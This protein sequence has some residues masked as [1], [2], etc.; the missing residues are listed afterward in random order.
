MGKSLYHKLI[1]IALVTSIAF[2]GFSVLN[3]YIFHKLDQSEIPRPTNMLPGI[4]APIDQPHFVS[5]RPISGP[6]MISN[7][8]VITVGMLF[9][10]LVNIGGFMLAEKM[11]VHI[12]KRSWVRYVAS[13]VI[14]GLVSISFSAMNN[15]APGT[16]HFKHQS[17]VYPPP[18]L[19][20]DVKPRPTFQMLSDTRQVTFT[21]ALV[22]NLIV[23]SILEITLLQHHKSRV[24]LENT[25]LKM[26]DLQARH[27]QLKHQLHPH[28]LFNSLN[29][30]K[31]LIKRSPP[32]AEKYLIRMSGLLRSSLSANELNVIPLKKELQLCVDYMEMQK[33]RFDG[34]F[35][36]YID[37]PDAV[38]KWANVPA[39]SLQ[40]LLENAIKHNVLT[41]E[42][43][44]CLTI[45]FEEDSHVY[46]WNNKK[47]KDTNEPPS[48]IG[49][50]NLSERYKLISGDGIIV[51]SDEHSFKVKIKL[52]PA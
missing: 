44:L 23:I 46:V 24:E 30:L 8:I 21:T 7:S 5:S 18:V 2:G 17:P 4:D 32:E 39:F 9:I 15:P 38:L 1:I 45:G 28:F 14:V 43:P 48:S 35:R 3:F 19:M 29:T 51:I 10:W 42:A 25:L 26:S 11:K 13:F 36:Y 31:A 47:I 37:V 41:I 52:L 12:L 50:K 16:L 49:L 40:L 6:F 20:G 27:Q 33:M 34:A 22:L